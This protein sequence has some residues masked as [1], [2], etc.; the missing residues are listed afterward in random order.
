MCAGCGRSY[1][2]LEPGLPI[3]VADPSWLLVDQITGTRVIELRAERALAQVEQLLERP[4]HRRE[5]ALQ[6]MAR[7]MKINLELVRR[8]GATLAA[9]MPAATSYARQVQPNP[10]GAT[11]A[12]G[13]LR[14]AINDWGHAP[15][16]EQGHAIVLASLRAHLAPYDRSAVAVLGGGAG[17]IACEL[18]RDCDAVQIF[19]LSAAMALICSSVR[20]GELVVHHPIDMNVRD[21]ED[22]YPAVTL[23]AELPAAQLA[24]VDYAIADVLRMPVAD[25]AFTAAVAVYLTDVVGSVTDLLREVHRVLAAGGV[26]VGFGTLGYSDFRPA[27]MWTAAELRE[28]LVEH[29]FAIAHEEWVTH[30]LWPSRI[31]V[32]TQATA[33]SFVAVKQ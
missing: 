9:C 23:T 24:R 13:A 29:G 19:D 3:L 32:E 7:G 21:V 16:N 26:F 2:T 17:R 33:W 12:I 31:L 6:R 18:A 25:G 5:A 22:L 1:P 27:E 30:R 8:W 15:A 11:A 20:R 4:G 10:P 14:Y 28:L